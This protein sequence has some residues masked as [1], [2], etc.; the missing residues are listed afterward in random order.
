MG[1]GAMLAGHLN[2]IVVEEIENSL[3]SGMLFVIYKI[4][5]S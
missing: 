4:R 5:L 1:F 3:T 2:P